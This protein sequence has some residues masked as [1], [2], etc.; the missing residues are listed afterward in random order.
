MKI[1]ELKESDINR[2]V[3][4]RDRFKAEYGRI[5]SYNSKFVFVDYSNSGRGI[6]TDPEQLAFDL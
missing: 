2:K 1:E 4:Y 5:T 3:I 6:A